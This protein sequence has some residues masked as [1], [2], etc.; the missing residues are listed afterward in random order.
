MTAR[1]LRRSA[2]AALW[3]FGLIT[4]FAAAA[5]LLAQ[6]G[7]LPPAYPR[8]GAEKILDNARVQV[9][10][11]SWLKQQYPLHR[12]RYDLVGVYYSPGDRTIV[13]QDGGRRPVSTKAWDTAF[14]RAGVT[15]IEEGASDA[16]L[17]AL[18]IEMKEAAASG[19]TDAST[20]PAPFSSLAG[21][22]FVD[23]ER[24]SGWL[25]Q[26]GHSQ[27]R[28]RHQR[29]AVILWF[30]GEKHGAELVPHGTV[31]DGEP[32]ASGDHVYV[33]ELK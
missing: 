22:P 18:F 17:R 21:Q 13:A 14:Q 10:D 15:H 1:P 28:H 11:I 8:P 6:S 19:Q 2:C 9:W 16:P 27:P 24:V 30:D 7:N 5:T 20:A 31:H 12:H 29:D 3:G 33:F 4:L 25:L 26:A 23:N 32:H